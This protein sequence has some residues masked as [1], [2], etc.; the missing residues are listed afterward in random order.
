MAIMRCHIV[1]VIV[2]LQH[3]KAIS[4]NFGALNDSLPCMRH[5]G[6]KSS[7]PI[8]QSVSRSIAMGSVEDPEPLHLPACSDRTGLGCLDTAIGPA[9]G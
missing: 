3:V 5:L 1:T 6:N 2:T 8:I 7:D 4:L 9:S